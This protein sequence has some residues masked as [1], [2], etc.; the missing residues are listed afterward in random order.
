MSA[1]EI[2]NWGGNWTQLKLEAFEAYVRAY[3]TIME[4]QKK[5]YKGWP[6]TIYFDG[7]AGSGENKLNTSCDECNLFY[8]N[9]SVE[10]LSIYRGSA[11]R[12]LSLDKKFDQYYFV[13]INDEYLKNLKITLK[14]KN[15]IC[16]SCEFIKDDV[17]NVIRKFS[18]FLNKKHAALILLDPFGMNINWN[19]IISLKDKDKRIDLWLLVPSGVIVNRLLDKEGKL[20]YSDTLESF[21]GMNKE[22]IKSIFYTT[23]QQQTLFGIDEITEKINNPIKKIAEIYVQKLKEVFKYVTETPLIL[24]NSRNVPIYHF[25]FASNNEI[26]LKIASQI[27]EKK[28]K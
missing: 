10:E 4:A 28:Q 19:S 21:F 27:I 15:L 26:A 3:L 9:I 16:K 12:I 11:E 7:F 1:K 5:K 8:N 22:E 24:L 17:N 14:S 25:V 6:T 2:S 18:D 20:K 23:K 13:D